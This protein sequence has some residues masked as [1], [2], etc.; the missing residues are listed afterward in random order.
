MLTITTPIE[1][2]IQIVVDSLDN[3]C[4]HHL[5]GKTPSI[6]SWTLKET[7]YPSKAVVSLGF[8]ENFSF[9]LFRMPFRV[10]TGT[11]HRQYYTPLPL[12]LEV[13]EGWIHD[14]PL[15]LPLEVREGWIHD[16]PLSLPSEVREGWNPWHLFV[17]YFRS[18]GS[19]NPWHLFVTYFRSEGELKSMTPLCHL[20]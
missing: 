20:L 10:S 15:S 16:T 1:E 5:I 2:L 7:L 8:V 17:T 13:R 11:S 9:I 6:H 3:L 4:Q 19:L 12:T 14:T 18:K